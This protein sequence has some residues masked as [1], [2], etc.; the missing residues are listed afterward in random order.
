MSYY[1]GFNPAPTV[2]P[3]AD[4]GGVFN[5]GSSGSGG[6]PTFNT[7]APA[8]PAG[9][10]STAAQVMMGL[11]STITATPASTGKLWISIKGII[12]NSTGSPDGWNAVLRWG[13][14]VAPAN[15]A[16]LTGTA[17]GPNWQGVVPSASAPYT[18]NVDFKVTGLAN[19]VPVWF[20]VSIQ[21]AVAGTALV[22]SVTATIVEVN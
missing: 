3:P 16:A 10:T 12:T 5:G 17:I 14:G 8:D 1:S 21:A 2:L 13:T 7:F 18:F 22:K 9:T 20:D 19:G 15:G 4:L 6:A 11:G